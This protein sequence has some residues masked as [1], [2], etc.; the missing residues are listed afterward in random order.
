MSRM[1][2]TIIILLLACAAAFACSKKNEDEKTVVTSETI[3]PTPTPVPT[4]EPTPP[5]PEVVPE[6]IRLSPEMTGFLAVLDGS[7]RAAGKALGRYGSRATKKND[8]G[9]YAL[10]D[11]K[12]TKSETIGAMQCYTFESMAGAVKHVTR[13]CWDGSGK[14]AQITDTTP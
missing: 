11:P 2:R 10:K 3:A 4:L 8:L 6:E 7:D 12:V 9:M 14:V 1:K 5:P 13:A